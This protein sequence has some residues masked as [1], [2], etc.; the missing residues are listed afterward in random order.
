[1]GQGTD[2]GILAKL[3]GAVVS[4]IGGIGNGMGNEDKQE[5][6]KE[7]GK[8]GGT[9]E[10]GQHAD[11]IMMLGRFTKEGG[12]GEGEGEKAMSVSV[13][14]TR[15]ATPVSGGGGGGVDK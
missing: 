4:G 7:K 10:M 3:K 6:K 12:E 15:V 2:E 9:L 5:E 8:V 1:M 13:T 11:E 14:P